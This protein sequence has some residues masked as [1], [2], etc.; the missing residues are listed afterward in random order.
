METVLIFAGGDFPATSLAEELPEA[1]LIVAADSGYDLAV[2]Q[3][4]AVDV[5]VGDLD[6]I[7]T[8]LIPGHVIVERHPADKDA[9]DLELALARVAAEHPER[10][11]VVGGAGGRVD[12]ELAVAALLTSDRWSAVAEI[13][14]VTERGWAHV[15]RSHRAIHGDVGATI[16]LIPMGGPARGVT[17]RGTR[18]NLDG[19]TLPHGTTHGVSNEFA[20][21]V[22][23][24]TVTEGCLLVVVPAG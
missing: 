7:E 5:L 17:T 21:P 24:V 15:V 18:W 20:A 23:D 12:H 19:A 13:D 9:T 4:F 8:E 14:W 3:G 6:S 2:A 16:S 11:V 1:D 10:I 22:I